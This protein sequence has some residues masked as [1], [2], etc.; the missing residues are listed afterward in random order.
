MKRAEFGQLVTALRRE[1][2]DEWDRQWTQ[3]KLAQETGLPLTVMG[4][5]ERGSKTQRDEAT[6]LQLAQALQLTSG[7]REA[8]FTAASGSLPYYSLFTAYC[9]LCQNSNRAS[10]ACG[11]FCGAPLPA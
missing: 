8:F 6:L 1:H 11:G 10:N 3:A 2:V 5:I 7:E 9:P 4:T